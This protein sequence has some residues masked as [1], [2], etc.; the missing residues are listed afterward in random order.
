MQITTPVVLNELPKLEAFVQQYEDKHTA[1]VALKIAKKVFIRTRLSEA[2]NWKCCWCGT[3]CT[4]R[5]GQ[6]NS[7]TI[8]HVMPQSEGGADDWDN[9][10]MSCHRCN[11]NRGTR[12]VDRFLVMVANGNLKIDGESKSYA[13]RQ[14]KQE[15]MK[16]QR[17]VLD[18][19]KNS[20]ENP[21]TV[22]SKEYKMFFRYTRS[23]YLDA[24]PN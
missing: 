22:G 20:M 11:S 2:Q 23:E 17:R 3:V 14:K 4:E 1:K 16:M 6:H 15:R 5:R 9:Y 12:E 13:R 18:A 21:F 8:E 19:I 24:K 10:A 7:T